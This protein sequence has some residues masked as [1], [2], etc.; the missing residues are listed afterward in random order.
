MNNESLIKMNDWRHMPAV[1]S[2]AISQP[3][4]A[5]E[6]Q[7]GSVL[8]YWRILFRRKLALILCG[9]IGLAGGVAFTF[10]QTPMYRAKTALEIQDNKNDA[11][12]S[13]LLNPV[14]GEQTPADP[15]TDIQTQ[16][17]LLQS[18]TLIERALSKV[19]GPLPED[20]QTRPAEKASWVRLLPGKENSRDSLIEKTEK[21]L[22]VSQS[23][24]TRVVEVSF[25]ATDPVMASRFANALTT[26]FIEQNLQAR[27]EMNRRTTDW[28]V[29]Q[30]DDLRIKLRHSEDALQA[31]ARQKGLIYTGDKQSVSEEK[32]RELQMELSKAQADRVER[33]VSLGNRP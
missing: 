32:L 10:L 26:E 15:L 22:K 4:Y 33:A 18:K 23:G 9:A 1:V 30:L 16:I 5:V 29:G 17:R 6:P 25:D 12:A 14:A 19:N 24:Q 31:Y 3:E 7:A 20:G 11:F 2:P 27:W 21:H 13:K 28:L 8:D